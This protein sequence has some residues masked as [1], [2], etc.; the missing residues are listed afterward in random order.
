MRGSSKRDLRSAA[1]TRLLPVVKSLLFLVS[2][3]LYWNSL[4]CDFVFDDVTAVK[5]NKD[6]RPHSA[7][8]NL[9]VNDFWGTPMHKERSHKS[10]RPLTVLTFRLNYAW[11]QLEPVTYHLV[12]VLLHASV[13]LLY[14]SVCQ[15][16]TKSDLVSLVASLLFALHPVIHFLLP[17]FPAFVEYVLKCMSCWYVRRKA[18]AAAAELTSS[19]TKHC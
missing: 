9:M 19:R 4:D 3:S 18:G 5:T 15:A 1:S 14:H 8:T 12:N 17:L 10:Y 13:T 6:L 11:A 16:L 2:L 7:W